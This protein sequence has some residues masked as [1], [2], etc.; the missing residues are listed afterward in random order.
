M[1]REKCVLCGSVHES[2]G[3][4]CHPNLDKVIG[5]YYDQE[6]QI[7]AM[8]SRIDRA[9]KRLS[10]YMTYNDYGKMTS[11]CDAQAILKEE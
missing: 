5:L 4:E 10:G 1:K 7:A 6:E 2:P 3:D 11:V 9:W 8:Q